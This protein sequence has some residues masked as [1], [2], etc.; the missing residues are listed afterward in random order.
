MNRQRL[1]ETLKRHEGIR[2]ELYQCSAGKNTIGYGRN[3]DDRGIDLQEAEMLLDTDIEIVE[4]EL[5]ANF[6]FYEFLTDPR[7]EVL[8][9]LCFQLGLPTLLKFRKMLVALQQLNYT[10]A[11]AEMLDSKW[12]KQCSNRAYELSEVM[13]TGKIED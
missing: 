8:L 2:L 3:L 1:K 6:S 13:R 9:N 5:R 7:Q 12:A 10:L 4:K 11:A